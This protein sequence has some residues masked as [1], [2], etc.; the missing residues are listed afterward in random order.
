VVWYYGAYR[1]NEC[2][3]WLTF[4][5]TIHKNAHVIIINQISIKLY[6]FFWCCTRDIIIYL[7]LNKTWYIF[8]LYIILYLIKEMFHV[9]VLWV[10]HVQS[11]VVHSSY[12]ISGIHSVDVIWKYIFNDLWKTTITIN[13]RCKCWQ[14][15]CQR[16]LKRRMAAHYIWFSLSDPRATYQIYVHR[17]NHIH[18]MML[19]LVGIRVNSPILNF[20]SRRLLVPLRWLFY[21]ILICM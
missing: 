2:W 16:L 7:S 11:Y 6:Y 14:L 9:T 4:Y 15:V 13:K 18:I 19:L 12:V 10:L 1:N 20:K 8:R 21:D 3:V 17:N 5:Y